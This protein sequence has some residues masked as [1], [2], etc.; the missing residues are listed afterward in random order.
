LFSVVKNKK[1]LGKKPDDDE[2]AGMFLYIDIFPGAKKVL[3]PGRTA[4]HSVM[5]LGPAG[6]PIL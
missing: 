4:V 1:F 6:A 5:A 2:Q 3:R